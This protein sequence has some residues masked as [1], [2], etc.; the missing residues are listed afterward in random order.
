MFIS[1]DCTT[2]WQNLRF[3]KYARD[4]CANLNKVDSG[5]GGTP[6]CIQF[7]RANFQTDQNHKNNLNSC[8]PGLASMFY[9]MGKTSWEKLVKQS[10]LCMGKTKPT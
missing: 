9:P 5:E 7:K 4:P 1:D 3:D 10:I 6:P 8:H 2:F